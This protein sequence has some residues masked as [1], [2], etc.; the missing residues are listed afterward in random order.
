MTPKQKEVNDVV[1]SPAENG[2]HVF[3]SE[4]F[5]NAIIA[6]NKKLGRISQTV[7]ISHMTVLSILTAPQSRRSL[8]T[9]E[10]G[11]AILG[12]WDDGGGLENQ[13]R[14]GSKE[15]VRNKVYRRLSKGVSD[16]VTV[17]SNLQ[18]YGLLFEAVET[19]VVRVGEVVVE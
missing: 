16:F 17:E 4:D 8:C 10:D 19:L 3:D 5:K 2:F 1:L 12:R 13:N 14:L 6:S 15:S 7:A 11:Q 9:S 18:E